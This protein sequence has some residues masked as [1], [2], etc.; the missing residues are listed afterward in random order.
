MLWLQEEKTVN[1]INLYSKVI[2]MYPLLILSGPSGVGKS[3][4]ADAVIEENSNIGYFRKITTRDKRPYDRDAEASFVTQK[5][6]DELR[7]QHKIVFSYEIKGHDYGIPI[8]SFADLKNGPRIACLGNFQ[9]IQSL[10]DAFNATTIYVTA[11]IE[12]II[13]RIKKREDTP[14]QRQKSIDACPKHLSD[15]ERFKELFEYEITNGDNLKVAQEELLDI[16]NEKI[17]PHRSIYNFLMPKS[18]REQREAQ[19]ELDK[20]ARFNRSS[21]PLKSLPTFTEMRKRLEEA[22]TPFYVGR[23][24]RPLH[25]SFMHGP[26]TLSLYRSREKERNYVDFGSFELQGPK[27]KLAETK[28][29]LEELFPELI[30]YRSKRFRMFDE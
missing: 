25:Y 9:L 26:V 23:G 14:E 16:V 28:L 20:E 15:Y 7:S 5:E 29:L 30:E 3:T 1:F 27:N 18:E 22:M 4:L 24:F 10:Y 12:D 19:N 6:Y 8:D 21:S 2:T 11:P 17:L 13:E